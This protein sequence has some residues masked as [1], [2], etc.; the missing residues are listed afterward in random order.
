MTLW[1]SIRTLGVLGD[2]GVIGNGELPRVQA[3]KLGSSERAAS[4]PNGWA[5]PSLQPH[6]GLFLRK[7]SVRAS[8]YVPAKSPS[9][10]QTADSMT[11]SPFFIL[12]PLSV[13][14]PL[15]FSASRNKRHF[16]RHEISNL[17]T[18]YQKLNCWGFFSSE[19]NSILTSQLSLKTEKLFKS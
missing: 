7:M 2:P 1:V 15:V 5:V 11:A 10:N 6:L 4:T 12:A 13:G 14:C 18:S 17:F 3:D 9:T 19:N 8:L 16:L